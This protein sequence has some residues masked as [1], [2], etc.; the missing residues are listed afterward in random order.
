M[1]TADLN[2]KGFGLKTLITPQLARDYRS[3]LVDYL[4]ANNHSLSVGGLEIHLA[5]EFGFC[6]GVDRAVEYA[7]ETREKVP[8]KQIWITGEIIH[9]PFVNA[10]LKQ[11]AIRFLDEAAPGIAAMAQIQ[12]GDA[13]L[14]PAFGVPAPMLEAIRAREAVIV[15][16]TCGSVLNVWKQVESNAKDGFTSIIHGKYGHEET[17]ATASRAALF[18]GGKYLV[19]LNLDEAERVALFMEAGCPAGPEAQ[20]LANDFA[21]ACSTGF[22]FTRDLRRVGIANQTTMLSS[23]SLAIARRIEAAQAVAFGPQ[24]GVHY[25]AFDTICSATQDRQDA[26]QVLLSI[27]PDLLLVIGGFNSSNTTHLKEMGDLVCPTFHVETAAALTAGA[28]THKPFGQAPVTTTDWLPAG[29]LKVGITAGASTPDLEVGKLVA[30]LLALRG[31]E[32]PVAP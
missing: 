7:Y 29:P 22:D 10:R 11:M 24:V 13:V 4:K 28:I 8:D 17:R 2:R 19:V 31:V 26:V 30:T 6:Y 12:P 5:R 23:E 18:S 9:N 16:T 14:L 25:R 3:P 20:A 32:P 27:K 15:D 21:R 1:T